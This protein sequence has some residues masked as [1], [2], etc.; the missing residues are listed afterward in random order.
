MKETAMSDEKNLDDEIIEAVEISEDEL[1]ETTGG[2]M[3]VPSS[4][5]TPAASSAAT[6]STC[7]YPSIARTK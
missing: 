6:R 4:A 3:T 1:D 2:A 7:S 5:C